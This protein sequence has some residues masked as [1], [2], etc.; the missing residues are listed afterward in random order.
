MCILRRNTQRKYVRERMQV[1]KDDVVNA[2]P[3][4]HH[5]YMFVCDYAQTMDLPHFGGEQ[6]GE[7]YYY[8]P[9]NINVFG[10]CD[11]ST[12]LM[13]AFIYNEGE[14][15]KGG[16]NV[17]SMIEMTL[18]NK[19]VFKDAKEKG[20]GECLTLVFDNCGGQNKNRMVLRYLLYLVESN[21]FKTVEA[22]FLVAGH[23]KNVCDRLFKELK[24]GFHYKNVY[25]M[26]QL[27]SV[28]NISGSITPIQCTSNNFF[29][30][31]TYLD[32]IYSRPAP[33]TIN[34]N[35]IFKAV[36]TKP[37]VLITEIIKGQDSKEQNLIKLK[38]NATGGQ[39]AARTRIIN[40]KKIKKEKRPGLRE[41]KQVDLYEKWGPLVPL[42]FR[43]EICPKPSDKII[44]SVKEERKTKRN[45]R[46]YK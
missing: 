1:A 43:D 13:E 33:G 2:I 46:K 16:N 6:P 41:I 30:W 14:G 21:V 29:D 12:E 28:C 37:G 15:K 9:L 7:V 25:T 31:D 23:T 19:G 5:H 40:S 4:P 39:K 3:W 10:T 24:R 27:M 26:N 32:R 38:K 42:E 34:K 18:K 35:H 36:G 44:N 8:S 45:I 20:P 11:Y 17:V 22:V